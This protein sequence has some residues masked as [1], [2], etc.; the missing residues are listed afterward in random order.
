[1]VAALLFDDGEEVE[2]VGVEAEEAVADGVAGGVEHLVEVGEVVALPGVAGLG[3][4]GG[5]VRGQISVESRKLSGRLLG[6]SSSP[7]R[8]R[9]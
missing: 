7:S 3:G 5:E 8:R 6:G 1:L 4:V 9:R 2:A